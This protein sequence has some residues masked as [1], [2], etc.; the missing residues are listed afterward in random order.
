MQSDVDATP[1]LDRASRP[2]CRNQRGFN[3]RSQ[4]ALAAL[5]VGA[6]AALVAAG[7]GV[8][9]GW[10][11]ASNPPPLGVY[12]GYENANA[13]RSLGYSVGQE[14]AYAM[15]YLDATSWSAM[16]SSAANEAASWSGSGYAMTF[17][18][19]LLPT[20]G[21]TLAQGAAGDYDSSYR[22]IARGLVANHEANSV[23]RIGWEFNGSWNTWYAD[24]SD[25]SQFV[26]YWQQIV[27]TMRSVSGANFKFEW[28][29]N[30]GDTT[31]DLANYYPGNSYV[32]V[33]AEDVYD[34]AWST[35]PGAST[36]FSDLETEP[37][38]LNWLTSFA[39]QHDKPVSIGEW[40]LGNGPG[41]AGRPYAAGN[42][43]VSG[44]DD[45]MFIDDMAKWI[46]RNHVAEATYFDFQSMALSAGQNPNSYN[47][48]LKDFGPDGVA[49]GSAGPAPVSPSW[50]Q[51]SRSPLH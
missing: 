10:S 26:S 29:P 18:V 36:E 12:L 34:Q 23:L 41:S 49:G 46:A 40:G 5:L 28:C 11:G 1:P 20:S 43:E 45:P 16:E 15:D 32:D 42:E 6:V 17:S 8:L 31:D 50:T 21:G 27:T 4:W 44:G 47:A 14:P 2:T 19:P 38:G 48:F 22:G 39:A 33:I 7:C 13:V 9:S 37:Y 30:V 24:S 3:G 51:I 35:Y 25:Q